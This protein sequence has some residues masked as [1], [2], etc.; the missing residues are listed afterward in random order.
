M[1]IAV[2]LTTYNGESFLSEQLDSILSQTLLPS[3]IIIQDDNSSDGTWDLLMSYQRR[4]PDLI[5]LYRNEKQLGAHKNFIKAFQYVS[6]KYIAPCDQDDIWMPEKLER[7]YNALS[8]NSCSIVA[9]KEFIRYENGEEIPNGYSMPLLEDCIFNHSVAGHLMLVSRDVIKVFEKVDNISFD[10]GMVLWA[11]CDKGGVVI[12]YHG[13]VWRRHSALVTSAYSNHNPYSIENV[14]KWRKLIRTLILTIKG[15]KSLAIT[16]REFAIHQVIEYF[17][18]NK[19]ELYLY[20]KLALNMMKQTPISIL[21]AGLI[22]GKIKAK[23]NEYRAYSLKNKIANRLF[24][25]CYP[26]VFWYDY[27]VHDSL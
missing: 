17:A 26:A 7:L 3:E 22:L 20:D 9:C 4:Y 10:F 19:N 23:K 27:H 24:N 8:E 12:N 5:H 15:E 21:R 1:S 11:A 6:A 25:L 14:S 13:C 18:R 16:E 2:V